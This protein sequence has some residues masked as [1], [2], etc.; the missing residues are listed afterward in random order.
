MNNAICRQTVPG[1]LPWGDVWGGGNP[2]QSPLIP[3]PVCSLLI[4]ITQ[5][6]TSWLVSVLAIKLDWLITKIN[7]FS[8]SNEP[9]SAACWLH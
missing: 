4:L 3:Y 7:A 1:W 8:D 9:S 5:I 6:P 2:L